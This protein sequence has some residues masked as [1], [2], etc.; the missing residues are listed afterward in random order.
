M[1][2]RPILASVRFSVLASLILTL[3]TLLTTHID[4][5]EFCGIE[6]TRDPTNYSGKNA[7]DAERLLMVGLLCLQKDYR[8]FFLMTVMTRINIC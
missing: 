5:F 2:Y 3:G 6:D 4:S 1:L 7:H 8:L